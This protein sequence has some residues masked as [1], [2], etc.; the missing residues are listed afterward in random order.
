MFQKCFCVN[1]KTK[2][3]ENVTTKVL[4]IWTEGLRLVRLMINWAVVVVAE[5]SACSPTLT[6]RVRI[7]PRHNFFAYLCLKKNENKPKRGRVGPLK[8]T[9]EQEFR[10]LYVSFLTFNP[11][12]NTPNFLIEIFYQCGGGPLGSAAD[13]SPT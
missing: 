12:R 6:I 4:R 5:W 11:F 9:Y 1:R 13:S 7:L 10:I 8:K 3:G 2:T